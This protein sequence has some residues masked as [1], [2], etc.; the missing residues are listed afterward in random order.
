MVT[1]A[2]LGGDQ[3][4]VGD[5]NGDCILDIATPDPNPG[6]CQMGWGTTVLYGDAD[7]GFGNAQFLPAPGAYPSTVSA[8]GPVAHP[9][10]VAVGDGCGGGISLYGVPASP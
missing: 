7:G 5:F 8:L 1:Y 9:N 4:A 10:L 6:G 2:I 3:I